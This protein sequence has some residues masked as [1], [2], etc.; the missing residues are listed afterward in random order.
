MNSKLGWAI[1]RWGCG[2]E[3]WLSACSA[4]ALIVSVSFCTW[5]SVWAFWQSYGGMVALDIPL[6]PDFQEL[7]SAIK[8]VCTWW[9][10]A[11]VLLPVWVGVRLSWPRFGKYVEAP[12][13]IVVI[14]LSVSASCWA[15][16]SCELPLS[17]IRSAARISFEQHLT[18]AEAQAIRN[19]IVEAR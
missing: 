2:R 18:D 4:I 9:Y 19:R 13:C 3:V 5:V 10:M 12:L 8:G 14:L 7:R 16:A 1:K 17:N 11:I 15:L 6:P